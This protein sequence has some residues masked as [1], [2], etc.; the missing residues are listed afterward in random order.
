M[1]RK[2]TKQ[3][4]LNNFMILKQYY[5]G[6]PLNL[7][8]LIFIKISSDIVLNLLLV[9]MHSTHYTSQQTF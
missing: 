1:N 9:V 8:V 2:E 6:Y 7:L 3:I 5:V 4:P